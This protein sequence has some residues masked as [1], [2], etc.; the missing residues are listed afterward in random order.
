MDEKPYLLAQHIYAVIWNMV[1]L[2]LEQS[3]IQGTNRDDISK[4]PDPPIPY[5]WV[6]NN[7]YTSLDAAY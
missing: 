2:G 3:V 1:S 7:P 4:L 5:F 6:G